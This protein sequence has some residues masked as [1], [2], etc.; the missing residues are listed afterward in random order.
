[1]ILVL[2]VQNVGAFPKPS[3]TEKISDLLA[4]EAE[5]VANEM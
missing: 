1:L 2:F 3:L 5:S 4:L